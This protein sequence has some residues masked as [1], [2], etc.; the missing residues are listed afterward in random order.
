MGWKIVRH[1]FVI[2]FG[3]IVE[4]LKVSV[5][6]MIIGAVVAFQVIRM[7]GADVVGNLVTP[8]P[9]YTGQGT[10][11]LF[12]ALLFFVGVL[13]VISWIA[14]SWHRFVLLEEYP[15]LFPA[16]LNRPIATYAGQTGKLAFLIALCIV[17]L[18]I[19]ATLPVLGNVIFLFSFFAIAFLW[20]RVGIILPGV[21]VGKR[22]GIAEAWRVTR[23]LSGQ[24]AS[25]VFILMFLNLAVSL[26]LFP[27]QSGMPL[28]GAVL[29]LI[30]SWIMMMLGISILTTLYGHLVE[31]RTLA[32]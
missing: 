10:S 7:V 5:G 2:L 15:G 6:P 22:M 20:F 13:F 17:P 21:A 18:G 8:D 3:N 19:A 12:V 28:V 9:T 30:A 26:V 14:V 24:I 31:G 32:E 11:S 29:E 25:V 27:I 1:A 23:P 4:A 16:V